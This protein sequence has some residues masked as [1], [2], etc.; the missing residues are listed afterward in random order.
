MVIPDTIFNGNRSIRIR[1]AGM[2]TE[3][4]IPTLS[5]NLMQYTGLKDKNGV[6]IYEG[7]IL[8]VDWGRKEYPPHNIGPVSWNHEEACWCLGEGGSPAHDAKYNMEVIGSVHES[9]E[10]LEKP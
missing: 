7:D 9:P 2:W 1:A 4:S 3:D 8:R 5:E 10:L 6:E